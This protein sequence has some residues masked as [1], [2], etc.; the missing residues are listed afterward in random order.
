[1]FRDEIVKNDVTDDASFIRVTVVL[2]STL[3][4]VSSLLFS[5][6]NVRSTDLVIIRVNE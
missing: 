3:I 6:I 4:T 1:M 5:C 2:V